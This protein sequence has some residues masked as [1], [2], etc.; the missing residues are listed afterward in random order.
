MLLSSTT[1]RAIA[2]GAID[3]HEHH[4]SVST[5]DA[6]IG[7]ARNWFGQHGLTRPR[8]GRLLGGVCAGLARR[9]G[10][11][12][13]VMR[14]LAVMTALFLTP[15]AYVALWVLMPRDP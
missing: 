9:Y 7:G 6:P 8:H 5:S 4:E 1:N 14:L 13:L 15:L 10:V 3:E 2:Q 12:L 11:N